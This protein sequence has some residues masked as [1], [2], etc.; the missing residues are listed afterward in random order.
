MTML[1]WWLWGKD[2]DDV[3][4]NDL[5]DTLPSQMAVELVAMFWMVLETLACLSL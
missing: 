4:S 5:R 3:D 2:G 1:G